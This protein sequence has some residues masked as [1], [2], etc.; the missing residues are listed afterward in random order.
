MQLLHTNG[1]HVM[2]VQYCNCE[3][4]PEWVQLL[5]H[6]LFP[7]TSDRPRSAFTF[8]VLKQFRTM[9]LVSKIAARD[10]LSSLIQLTSAAFPSDI[11][12]SDVIRNHSK[13]DLMLTVSE[14]YSQCISDLAL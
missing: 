12:V 6:C 9:N 3:G 11:P 1:V 7:G 2:D 10:Y 4:K 5:D 14:R 13:C 8:A